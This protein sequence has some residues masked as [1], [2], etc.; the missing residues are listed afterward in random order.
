MAQFDVY[1]NPGH[2][3]RH[4]PFLLDVQSD[5]ISTAGSS[6]VVP[7]VRANVFGEPRAARLYPLFIVDGLSVVMVTTDISSILRPELGIKV[8]SLAV[9][10]DAIRDALDFLFQG[11]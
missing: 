11:F 6:V 7:L 10:R 1:R 8:T 2:S 9:Q 4:V 3:A 5:L